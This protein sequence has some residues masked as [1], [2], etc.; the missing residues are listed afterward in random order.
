MK[1]ATLLRTPLFL[2]GISFMLMMIDG[3][4]MLI[5]SFVAPLVVRDLRLDSANIGAVFAAGLAGSAVGGLVLGPLADRF[6]RRPILIASLIVAGIATLVCSQANSVGAFILIRSLT[7]FALGGVL[8]TAIP[9]TAEHFPQEQRSRAVTFM[10]IGY[11]LGAVVGGAVT[12]ILISHGWRGLLVGTG[13]LALLMVPLALLMQET[14]MSRASIHKGGRV[15]RRRLSIV[16]LFT[17]GRLWPTLST[18]LG[19]FSVLLLAYLLNS[20]TP[21]I[22]VRLG[23]NPQTAALCG[24]FLNLGGVIGALCSTMLVR[25]LGI[26]KLAAIM[27][28]VGS[29]TVVCIGVAASSPLSLFLVLFISGV[30]VIGAQQNLPAMSVHLYPQRMRAAGTGWQFAAGRV[31]SILGPLIGAVL[32]SSGLTYVTLFF[33]MAIPALLAGCSFAVAHHLQSTALLGS[34]ADAQ[35][36]PKGNPP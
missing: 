6:G 11:P 30:L 19:I 1:L 20:W 25:R 4:D 17:E 22:A 12:A 7:G 29:V 13:T 26:F 28:S 23:F 36:L 34:H 27:V 24:V 14:L 10:F 3:Y 8:T 21:L 35:A 31:G 2:V 18:G 16:E 15:R 33:V 5:M 9:L 32:L